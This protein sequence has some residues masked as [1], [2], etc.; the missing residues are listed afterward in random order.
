MPQ[1]ALHHDDDPSALVETQESQSVAPELWGADAEVAEAA[2]RAEL[3]TA[4]AMF[5]T[6]ETTR[7][8][9]WADALYRTDAP[10]PLEAAN[11]ALA[12]R[13]LPDLSRRGLHIDPKLPIQAIKA[14]DWVIIVAAADFAARWGTGLG[15]LDMNIAA[16][17]AFAAIAV[18]LK[19][20]LW[21][22]D[23]YCT[24]PATI[25]AERGLGGLTLGAFIGL[26]LANALAPSARDAGSLSA[27]LPLTAALLA[28]VHAALAAWIR[29][30]Q[31]KGVFSETIVVV[32]ATEAAERFLKRTTKSGDARIIAIADDR[33]ERA[34]HV[35]GETPVG[36]D[37]EA[38]LAWEGLPHVDRIVIA[39]TPKAEAR[40]R[41]IIA[42]LKTLPN[43]VDLLIDYD[44]NGVQGRGVQRLGGAPVVSV[45]G[46]QRNTARALIKSA[47]DFVL[48]AAL[49]VAFAL[50]ML[51]IAAVVK[52]TSKGAVF[53]RERR[54]GLNNR[55]FTALKFRTLRFGGRTTPIG[56]FLR[57][58]GLDNLPQLLNVMRGEMSLVGPR[59]HTAGLHAANRELSD[60]VADYAHRHR[61]KPG[62]TGWAQLQ[63]ACGQPQTPACVRK[64]VRLDLEYISRA[65]LLL[66]A[67]ILLRTA[68]RF[69]REPRRT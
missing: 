16:A 57:R 19:A 55:V 46:R 50:P 59:P 24:T 43:R 35:L 64:C 37:I 30:A 22:T 17:M 4:F 36:G 48:G 18:A 7:D 11:D 67:Q 13:R 60:I 68:L 6:L 20:G 39:V 62:I 45:S 54:L 5:G 9:E 56:G 28:G 27:V 66:D 33:L 53:Y 31:K 2:R 34:P 52:L 26:L 51:A 15:L 63:G 47:Q 23:A 14:L 32:G 49:L 38:L 1:A 42:R 61:V 3:E 12:Q 29:A 8:G 21:L 25:R 40:V 69:F 10:S 41:A 44:V 58:R 65:S